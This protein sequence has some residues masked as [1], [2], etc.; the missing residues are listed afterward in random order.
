MSYLV[1]TLLLNRRAI[2]AEEDFTSDQY[3]D[4]LDVEGAIR[5][6]LSSGVLSQRDVIILMVIASTGNFSDAAKIL[7]WSRISASRFYRKTCD[8]IAANLGDYFT[9]IGYLE[10]MQ[11]KYKLSD[12]Q[13]NKLKE[14]MSSK[15]RYKLPRTIDRRW[16]ELN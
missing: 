7:G 3:H 8:T 1:E 11:D 10:Y 4:L 9:D 16:N 12:T 15:F 2:R 5:K 6:L 13:I 14:F